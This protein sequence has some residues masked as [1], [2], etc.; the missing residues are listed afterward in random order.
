MKLS[1]EQLKIGTTLDFLPPDELVEF[2]IKCEK[3]GFD[4]LWAVDH[5]IDTGGVKVEP[6][7]LIAAIGV[8]T[9]KIEFSTSVTDTYR[10]HPART[11]QT[12]ATLSEI[13]GGRASLGIGAGEAMNIVP[14]GMKFEPPAQRAERLAEAI[15]IVRLLWQSDRSRPVSFDGSYFKLQNAW[16]DVRTK[17]S[18]KIIVGALGGRNGLRVA[19]EYGDGWVPWINTPETYEKRLAIVMKFRQAKSLDPSVFEPTAWIMLSLADGGSKLREAISATK[20]TLLAEI[21]TLKF[22]GFKPAEDLTPYQQMIVS[23]RADQAINAAESMI[24]DELALKFLVCGTPSEI[25][26]KVKAYQKAGAKQVL[27]EFQERGGDELQYFAKRIMPSLQS[28]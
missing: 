1:E 8:Q 16:L 26:E 7:T 14:F 19:G 21:H 18:P 11:A 17:Y 27:F 28:E 22:I 23:D 6:W 15:R 10:M 5:L 9:K 24:P 20:K 3:I 2:G 13:T 25:V 12:V 4:S